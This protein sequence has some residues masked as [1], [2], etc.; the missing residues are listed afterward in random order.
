E[1]AKLK[2]LIF[3]IEG[4]NEPPALPQL[5]FPIVKKVKEL[6]IY[7]ILTT[8]GV[9]WKEKKLKEL[10]ELGWDRIH[11][12]V[13]SSTS[14]IH[15]RLTGLKGSFRKTVK[16]ILLLNK[17]KRKM[18]TERPMLNINVCV[19][20]LNFRELPKI[21]ELARYLKADYIFTEP[22]MVYTEMG[23][24]LKPNERELKIL[25]RV[26]EKAKSL[27]ESLGID[28]NFST[29]DKNLEEE[30][31]KSTGEMEKLLLTEVKDLPNGLISSPCFKPWERIA[32]RFNGLTGHCG[33]I[34]EGEN[35]KEKDLKEI[36]FGSYFKK[37]RERMLKKQLFPHCHKCVPSDF[38]QK[39]RFRKEL[40]EFLGS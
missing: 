27:A 13:H 11:F 21:V 25:S 22:I 2:I 33:F 29:Q 39:K 3:N 30:I 26:I 10:V 16:N 5:F 32:I 14:K 18:K 6:G 8:N 9:L 12:S 31:V 34:E 28:N 17:W 1:A 19:N 23:R 20:K 35:V 4:I 37:V 40:I 7:G 15:D 24:K 38:T 36:W